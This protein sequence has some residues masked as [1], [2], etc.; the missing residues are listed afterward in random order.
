M[1]LPAGSRA[2]A[3]NGGNGVNETFD[4]VLA[5]VMTTGSLGTGVV[6]TALALLE[7][8]KAGE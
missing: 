7:M 4:M 5:V 1:E 2:T 8:L 3:H 6:L